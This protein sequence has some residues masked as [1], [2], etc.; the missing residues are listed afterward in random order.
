MSTVSTEYEVCRRI[1]VDRGWKVPINDA[2]SQKAWITYWVAMERYEAKVA[3]GDPDPGRPVVP[4][5]SAADIATGFT[6]LPGGDLTQPAA[7]DE[8][9]INRIDNCFALAGE[10]IAAQ[11]WARIKTLV[12]ARSSVASSERVPICGTKGATVSRAIWDEAWIAYEKQY[13]GGESQHKR[14]L[15]EGFYA[16]ELDMFRPGWRPVD[17]RIAALEATLSATLPAT[18]HRYAAPF[19]MLGK[20]TEWVQIRFVAREHIKDSPT[21]A[22]PSPIRV[23]LV[24]ELERAQPQAMAFHSPDDIS[25]EEKGNG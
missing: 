16:G 13:G 2:F 1:A 15:R 6:L 23:I 21:E 17:Q 8:E 18:Q 22:N 11:D 19:K 3:A 5:R 9:A 14:L 4:H 20:E 10:P 24:G 7:S 25:R 12:A